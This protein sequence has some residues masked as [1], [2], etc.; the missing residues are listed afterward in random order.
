LKNIS[1]YIIIF[2]LISIIIYQSNTIEILKDTTQNLSSQKVEK[3][4]EQEHKEIVK[5]VIDNH[6]NENQL[7]DQEA[8]SNTKKS[9]ELTRIDKDGVSI[10]WSIDTK[11]MDNNIRL[12]ATV[13]KNDNQDRKVFNFKIDKP[14]NQDEVNK[15][16]KRLTADFIKL[17][18]ESLDEV[19][20]NLNLP[21]MGIDGSK[22]IWKSD[23]QNVVSNK[24]VIVR[25][26]FNKDE[27]TVIL[28][29]TIT[30]NGEEIEKEFTIT[31][32]PDE[33]E[34]R[35]IRD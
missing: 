29:A 23:N 16:S 21:E 11:D 3:C 35:E 18:N 13:S 22:I 34:I 31:V 28:I 14:S 27:V 19:T 32:L 2:I 33:S 7:T 30:Q 10:R 9:L 24:G 1:L 20:S 6:I 4:Q 25:P 12:I 5:E 26:S 15:I 8:V 17:E